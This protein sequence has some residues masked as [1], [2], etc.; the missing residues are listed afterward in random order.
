[1][2]QVK[3]S[4]KDT[5]KEER[6]LTFLDSLCTQGDQLNNETTNSFEGKWSYV[7]EFLLNASQP[8]NQMMKMCRFGTKIINCDHNFTSVLTD[9]G[10][11]C[12]FNAI[13]PKLLFNNFEESDHVDSNDDNIDYMTWSPESGYN[14]NKKDKRKP[15]P[16][17]VPGNCV[18][19][20][21]L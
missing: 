3:K 7:R 5:L 4:F 8:C 9:E 14:N 13:Y 15:Y 20:K 21:L 19:V 1:M 17:P 11:C 10:L 2:N 18:C 6:D 12:T 16:N